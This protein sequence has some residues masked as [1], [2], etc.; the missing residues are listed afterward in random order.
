MTSDGLATVGG[1]LLGVLTYISIPNTKRQGR[2]KQGRQEKQ[3]RQGRG[4]QGRMSR[5]R[6]WGR[7]EYTFRDRCLY[8]V[9][10]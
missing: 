8:R 3:G 5:G 10:H 7:C 6:K 1:L 4:R 9:W 2:A